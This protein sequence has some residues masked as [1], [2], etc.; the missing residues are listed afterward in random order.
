PPGGESLKDTYKR[1]VPYFQKEIMPHLKKSNVLISAH[2]N[3]L[4]AIIKYLDNISD[5]EI[6]NLELPTGIPIV[7]QYDKG[8]L[9]K[10]GEYD[11]TRPLKWKLPS[12][13]RFGKNKAFKKR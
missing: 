10:L 7:Y 1:S 4:R 12:K 8:N 11:F 13:P 9:I 2:G 3:S 5:E 6:P